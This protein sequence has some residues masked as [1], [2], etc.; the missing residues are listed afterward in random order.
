MT[1]RMDGSPKRRLEWPL[2]RT[3]LLCLLLCACISLRAQQPAPQP[4][5]AAQLQKLA[6]AQQWPQ[7]ARL[8]QPLSPRT[9][10]M[11]YYL[12]MALARTGRLAAAERSLQAGRRLAPRDPRFP[13]E[14]A[15]I[16][17][18]RKNYPRAARMLRRAIKLEPHSKY[19]N[20]F[21]ATVYFLDG[22]LPAAVKYWNRIGKPYIAQVRS[23]PVPSVSPALL[24]HAFAFSP[25][26]TLRLPQLFATNQ[27]I[28]GLSIFPQYHFDLE[29]QPNGHF[30]LVFRNRQLNGF[31]GGKWQAAA[32]ILRGLPFQQV[33]P[34]FYNFRHRA[35]NFVS[36]YRWDAQKRRIYAHLSGPFEGRAKY[37]WNITADLRDE[38][39]A[40]R[41][42]F[43]GPAPLLAALNLRREM[44]AFTLAS[45][46]GSRVNWSA[47]AALSHRNFR[48]VQPGSVLTPQMLASGYQLKQTAQ[49]RAVLWR[50]PGHRFTLSAHAASQAGRLWSRS[51]ES[52]EKLTGALA[53]HWFP[54][55]RGDDY[56]M[57][58][59]IRAGHTFGQ[60]P[61]DELFILGLD[62]DNHLPMRAHIAT[63]DGRKGS[64]PMGRD[65]FLQ[66][67]EIDK[68]IYSNGIV[69]VQL[70]P[71]LDI[72]H[73]TDPGT[74]LG[75]HRWLF[76]TGIEAK[77]RVFGVGVAF[78]Y[79]KDLRTGNNAFYALPLNWSNAA[80]LNQ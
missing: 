46:A 36:M 11:D 15:G 68:N 50:A 18:K 39:W 21:L 77:L 37:R 29:A 47:G 16:A 72:G 33:N 49:L 20:N 28:H 8:L 42:S 32:L 70:G 26:A 64:A 58:Q 2:P 73:I 78:S 51:P 76:D 34:A 55:A 79:G 9:A 24:D 22:N 13:V 4:P 12:G 1:N 31:G 57:S 43:T 30:N 10:S 60:V 41:N 67:W 69:R 5:T 25:A 59:Q 63:R 7:I 44:A 74:A 66:N 40:L 19:A 61:F 45:Y 3:A 35:I 62:Q 14:L 80:A 27:R 53:W 71:F 52:F 6:A 75:S 65:Y 56:A 38:N 54:R 23:E 48:G 17:F